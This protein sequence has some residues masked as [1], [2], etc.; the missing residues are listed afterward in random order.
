VGSWEKP[1]GV[2]KDIIS[3]TVETTLS[4]TMAPP[5]VRAAMKILP[6]IKEEEDCCSYST[7]SLTVKVSNVKAGGDA[8]DNKMVL[9]S[10]PLVDRIVRLRLDAQEETDPNSARRLMT[11]D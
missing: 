4:I 8:D 5:A 7:G 9:V 6:T 2:K 10:F 1:V 11:C 3:V